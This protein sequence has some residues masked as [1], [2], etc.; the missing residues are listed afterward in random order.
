MTRPPARLGN[1]TVGDRLRASGRLSV[2][3]GQDAL[4]LEVTVHLVP[5][6]ALDEHGARDGFL[7][8]VRSAVTVQHE[9][10]LPYVTGGVEEAQGD[11]P[12]LLYAAARRLDARGLDEVLGRGGALDPRRVLSMGATIAEV[13]AR[14]DEAGLRHGDLT[15][16]RIRLPG[17]G[18][19]VVEP[20]R[21][22]PPAVAP[23]RARYQAPEEARGEPGDVRSDL[24]VLGLILTEA[25]T[26][27]YPLAGTAEQVA[28]ILAAGRALDF[29]SR[30][31]ALP[32]AAAGVV[33]SLLS[34]DPAARLGSAQGA[35]AALRA[36][37]EGREPPPAPA[38]VPVAAPIPDVAP[39]P[40][41][42][43]P[44]A[45][46]LA[47][48]RPETA[49]IDLGRPASPSR[50]ARPAKPAQRTPPKPQHDRPETAPVGKLDLPT[51]RP[52][53]EI[54]RNPGRL[55]VEARLGEAMLE[56]DADAWV[57]HPEGALDVQARQE[58]FDA[59]VI[60]IERLPDGDDLVALVPGVKVNDREVDRVT[61]AAGD[62]VEAPRVVGRYE[63]AARIAMR[64]TGA[65]LGEDETRRQKRQ[66]NLVLG[67]AALAS[68][69]AV[70]IG[71][72]KFA[73]AGRTGSDAVAAAE[74]A[75]A[76]FEAA[77]AGPSDVD[78]PP[79]GD[80]GREGRAR[81]RFQSARQW[82]RDNPAELDQAREKLLAVA[83]EYDDTGW[84]AIARME[85]DDLVRRERAAAKERLDALLA[86]AAEDVEMG[87]LDQALDDLRRFAD[88]REGTV[89]AERARRAMA[90]FEGEVRARY[91][92]DMAK[93]SDALRRRDWA[94][95]INVIDRVIDYV[96]LALRDEAIAMRTRVRNAKDELLRGSEG[97]PPPDEDP[98]AGTDPGAGSDPTPP[99]DVDRPDLPQDPEALDAAALE[100]FRAARNAMLGRR[101]VEALDEF[102]EFLELYGATP[103]ARTYGKEVRD[104]IGKLV[105]GDAGVIRLFHGEVE[106]LKEGRYRIA[107]D[108]TEPEHAEDFLDLESFDNPPRA[109]WTLGRSGPSGRGSGAYVLDGHFTSDDLSVSVELSSQDMHDVGAIFLEPGDPQRFYLFTIRNTFFRLG[110]GPDVED[111]EENA[112]VLFGRD[113]WS[114][115]PSGEL[116]FVRKAG[117][118]LPRFPPGSTQRF[119][120]GKEGDEAWMRFASGRTIRGSAYGDVKYEFAGLQPG[121]F[122]LGSSAS[123]PSFVVEGRPDPAWVR[124]EWAARLAEFD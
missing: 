46:P 85:A 73:A 17:G 65:G 16:R 67:A 18:R 111:F 27:E 75:V 115:T 38:P 32:P 84:G 33:A 8:A 31:R 74:A 89:H 100:A 63:R 44:V 7:H 122:V 29:R 6:E 76:E 69:I 66:A 86:Q 83:E 82:A 91:D 92:A 94:V 96:P 108:F 79:D 95:A 77:E 56:L 102:L 70:A 110:K 124:A 20:I 112:I 13:L 88:M 37:A 118:P 35:A 30:L 11:S 106:P 104:R 68:V 9:G 22:V 90:A 87:L 71:L 2:H 41:D 40:D 53:V 105:E 34:A 123:F 109:K 42:D 114:D 19:V 26:G 45:A 52:L 50:P 113:M 54:K 72:S 47:E 28:K 62:R 117:S 121:M 60:R 116:G 101:D 58:P 55:Y 21:L 5:A 23:R 51:A 103:T 24:F 81:A 1:L 93:V 59:A 14:L 64:A 25:A 99:D 98:V 78:V 4:G 119:R 12:E 39:L 15:P 61:L 3:S 10:L 57:G 97:A 80:Q 49:P 48:D 36:V 107:Y 120:C 43:V